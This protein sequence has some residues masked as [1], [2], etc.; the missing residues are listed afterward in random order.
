MSRYLLGGVLLAIVLGA[1]IGIREG[2]GWVNDS[3]R[4]SRN[5][6]SANSAAASNLTPL[7]SAGQNVQRQS[8]TG[9]VGDATG[10]T[11]PGATGDTTPLRKPMAQRI[12]RAHRPRQP[13]PKIPFPPYGRFRPR[14]NP[15]LE[16]P[17]L[18]SVLSAH[19]KFCVGYGMT[20][21]WIE[22]LTRLGLNF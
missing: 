2:N 7:E 17:R 12:R 15:R 16:E 6:V 14:L 1:L 10:D 4:A 22:P 18:V 5:A 3:V 11:T 8:Q 21:G 9:P 20:P 19:P 13:L